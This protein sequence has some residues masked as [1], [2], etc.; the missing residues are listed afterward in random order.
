MKKPRLKNPFF[1]FP[2]II[3]LINHIFLPLSPRET[4]RDCD[5]VFTEMREKYANF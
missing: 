3:I 4:A 2:V 5:E 1:K